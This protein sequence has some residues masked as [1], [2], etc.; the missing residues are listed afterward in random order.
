MGSTSSAWSPAS[1]GASR[2][3]TRPPRRA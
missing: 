3:A 1:P 2:S